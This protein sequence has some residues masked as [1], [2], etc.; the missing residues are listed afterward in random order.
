MKLFTSLDAMDRKLLLLCLGAVVVVAALIG[1]LARNP[2]NDD[3]PIPNTYLT[4]KHGARAAYQ[5]LEAR[6]YA[7]QRWERPLSALASQADAQTVVIL[8]APF[9][10][11]SE[12]V[13][14]IHEILQ[15]GGRV[16]ATGIGGGRLLPDGAAQP[17]SQ[18]QMAAC[19]LTP[20]GLDELANSGEVWMVPAAGWKLSSPLYRVQYNCVAEPAVVEYKAGAGQVVWWASSTPLENGA[21]GR[22]QNMEFFLNALGSREGHHFY[23]DESLHGETRSQWFY[24][25]GPA[26]NMLL[27]GLTA[28]GVLTLL[29]F[30]R[31]RGPVRD[32]PLQA[33]NSPVEFLEALGSLYAKAGAAA[34]AVAIAYDRFRRKMGELCGQNGMQLSAPELAAVLRLRF[35]QA[36]PE[37]ETDLAACEEAA[38]NDAL[39]PKHA[40]ALVQ[41]LDQ[42][43]RLLHAAARAS[44]AEQSNRHSPTET[45]R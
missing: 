2:N 18:L 27:L 9:L 28:L 33:R 36:G 45:E 25:R 22:A 19:K 6:G 40:L 38:R 39:S 26:M 1:V 8:A 37:M 13:Q 41:A 15:R 30:S 16:L 21:I 3:N 24:A 17:A 12:D 5:L 31:R 14:A 34:T 4:G 32:L 10:G 23:W 11:S 42:H 44:T 29:S 20:Q 7:L 35:P 43:S